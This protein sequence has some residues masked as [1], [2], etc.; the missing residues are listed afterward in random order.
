MSDGRCEKHDNWHAHCQ[1]CCAERIQRLIEERD[2][3]R[4]RVNELRRELPQYDCRRTG[5]PVSDISGRHCPLDKPC[6]TCRLEDT[7]EIV[8]KIRK[9]ALKELT[10]LSE[11]MG[12]Y[13]QE[14]QKKENK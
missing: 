2:L 10:Q 13:D 5:G 6:L 7:Q 11:E 9:E 14:Y 3:E 4:H 12:L 1:R 8:N